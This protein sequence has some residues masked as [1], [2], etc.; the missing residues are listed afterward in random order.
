VNPSDLKFSPNLSPNGLKV[1]LAEITSDIFASLPRRIL[2]DMHSFMILVNEV[3]VAE[4]LASLVTPVK[5]G[6]ATEASIAKTAIT[7]TS[8]SREKPASVFRICL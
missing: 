4:I 7:T 1:E 5:V 2:V 8:S 6:N 3:F